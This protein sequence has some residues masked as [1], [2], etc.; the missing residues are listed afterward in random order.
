M[1]MVEEDGER[2]VHRARA[3][4][5][6]KKSGRILHVHE[7]RTLDGARPPEKGAAARRA[8][9]LAKRLMP[10]MTGVVLARLE[11]VETEAEGDID[12]ATH[13][14]DP[15]SRRVKPIAKRTG[16]AARSRI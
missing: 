9:E 3:V 11:A 7:I 8:M 4:V 5:Y 15:K 2:V 10:A 16:K 13:R 6:D 1:L 14:V 12:A